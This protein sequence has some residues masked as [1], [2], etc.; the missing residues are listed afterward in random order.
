L[1]SVTLLTKVYNNSQLGQVDRSLR[2][3]LEGLKVRTSVPGADSRGW[4]NVSILGEDENVA[5]HYLAEKV[6]ICPA[7]LEEIRKYSTFKGFVAD[8][9]R[10]K[11]ELWVD[12][13][14]SSPSSVDAAVP[15]CRLQSQLSDGRKIALGKLA[16]LFGFC[17]NLPLHVR[18]SSVDSEKRF[19]EAELSE[20]QQRQ[21]ADWTRS[22]LDRLL[23]L[24]VSHG[25]VESAIRGAGFNRDVVTV[26]SLGM[27]EHAVVCKLGTD[28][29]GLIPTVGK[30]LRR[31]VF[32]VFSP[33][34][35][36]A[37]LGD[38]SALSTFW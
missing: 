17:E 19:V 3:L 29:A 5:V 28:A 2:S 18:V 31:A 33:R 15:L 34:K 27:F 16:E 10:S 21:Y 6:G 24:G 14:V 12:V 22:L 11:N 30:R 23:V 38:G 37:L 7:G 20:R 26:E 1:A 13:G 36:L 9:S 8:P 32:S 35:V 25:E 4:V